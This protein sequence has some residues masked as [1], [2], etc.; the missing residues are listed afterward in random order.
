ML[1]SSAFIYHLVFLFISKLEKFNVSL[2]FILSFQYSKIL[3][4]MYLRTSR[5]KNLYPELNS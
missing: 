2:S 4:L 3:S 5:E 1:V